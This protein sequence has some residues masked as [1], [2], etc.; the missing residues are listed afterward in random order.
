MTTSESRTS[1]VRLD[2]DLT[3]QTVQAAR[4]TLARAQQAAYYAHKHLIEHPGQPDAAASYRAAN[5]RCD[6]A[7]AAL[8]EAETVRERV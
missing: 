3:D 2:E 8:R 5:Q 6:E 7:V 1:K 4:F